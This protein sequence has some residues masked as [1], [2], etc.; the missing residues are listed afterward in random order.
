M[1]RRCTN[2]AKTVPDKSEGPNSGNCDAVWLGSCGVACRL[3][4]AWV[5]LGTSSAQY[6]AAHG[7]QAPPSHASDFKLRLILEWPRIPE[8]REPFQMR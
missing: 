7:E 2:C 4:L 3:K 8:F 1:K 6:I 5:R